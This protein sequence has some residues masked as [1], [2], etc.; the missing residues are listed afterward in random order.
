MNI[1]IYDVQKGRN[2]LF[3]PASV[4]YPRPMNEPFRPFGKI[5]TARF[6]ERPNRF[7]VRC[8]Q[9]GREID[10]FLPNSGRLQELL[11]P[12][13]LLR[14]IEE[15]KPG[16]R[17]TTYTVVA[18][19]RDGSPVM[20][21]TLK[22]NAVAR[23]L[24]ER[25]LVP[26]LEDAEIE[27]QEKKVGHS[28]FDFLL[29]RGREEVLLEV[30][31]C[32]LFGKRVAM[33]PDAVTARGERHLREL[34]A[35]G[36]RGLRGAVL[37][38]VHWPALE[39]FMPDYHTDIRFARTFL[40][41]RG[42][43]SLIP[44]AVRW[45]EDLSLSDEVRLL[46]IPWQHVEQEA[47]DRGGYVLMLRMERDRLLPFGR[48]RTSFFPKGFYLYVGSA[49]RNLTARIGRHTRLRKRH[50]WHIDWLRAAARVHGVFPIRSSSK[51]ECD[52]AGALS[53]LSDWSIPGFG[54]SDCS[55]PTHLFGL[56]DDPLR[57]AAF[58]DVLQYFRMDRLF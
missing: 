28:R 21:H 4:W 44:V 36:E 56:A 35:L 5:L 37:F 20:L 39:F 58:H 27:K 49:M 46:D 6:L 3:S 17:K 7:L 25:R 30:K 19:D 16:T 53:H 13:R 52:L 33:F 24:L 18:V 11:L 48:D 57:S 41:V 8:E 26:G 9:G 10:A 2:L 23:Y 40:A 22:T 38:V 43:V 12:G 55:C 51:I 1:I 54:C 47:R 31:S 15:E 29:R 42:S 50:H 45:Q 32:T 14:V 34:A